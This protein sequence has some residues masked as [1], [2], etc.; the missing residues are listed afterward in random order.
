MCDFTS[1][2]SLCRSKLWNPP[3][4]SA[5]GFAQGCV[6]RFLFSSGSRKHGGQEE[7]RGGQCRNYD[8][9]SSL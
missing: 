5:Q 2:K 8:V 9:N 1:F 4:V 3:C 6:N 7:E